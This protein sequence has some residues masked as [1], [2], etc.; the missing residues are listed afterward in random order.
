MNIIA[1]KNQ[2]INIDS[3]LIMTCTHVTAADEIDPEFREALIEKIQ[4]VRDKLNN[5]MSK[6]VS[7]TTKSSGMIQLINE[8]GKVAQ[9]LMYNSANAK[10][11]IIERWRKTYGQKYLRMTVKDVPNTKPVA[12]KFKGKAGINSK[13]IKKKHQGPRRTQGGIIW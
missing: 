4:K 7:H 12:K 6:E 11:G 13:S 9:E 5:W 1:L 8:E 3:L 10:T 2:V